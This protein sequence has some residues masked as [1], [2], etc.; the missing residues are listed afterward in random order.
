MN[1]V[2]LDNSLDDEGRAL[3]FENPED[4]VTAALP[5]DVTPALEKLTQ[6]GQQGLYAAGFFSYE[7][8]YLMEPRLAPL[9]PEERDTPL[10]WFGIYRAPQIFTGKD[11]ETYLD[12]VGTGTYSV[13]DLRFSMMEEDY[14]ECFSYVKE[15]IAQGDI[16]QLNLTLKGYFQLA[17][18][19]VALYKD[20][21]T[22]QKVAFGAVIKNNFGTILSLSP[23]LFLQVKDGQAESRPMK[24][25]AQRGRTPE[26]DNEIKAWLAGDEKSRAENLM[27]VDLMRND[28][29]RVSKLGS[30]EVHAPYAVETYR[31]LHQMTTSVTATL[32]DNIS[33]RELLRGLFP[34]GSI[35]G[36]PKVRAMELIRQLETGPRGVYTGSIG[37]LAPNG[38]ACFN[39]A[40]R[41][42]AVTPS[43]CGEIGIGSGVVHDS[44][45]D[46][47]YDECLLKMRFLTDTP[48]T[49]QLI[50]T[51]LFE[52][53]VGYAYY[54]QH[55]ARL[56]KSATYFGFHH[57]NQQIID[58]LHK[59]GAGH[60]PG[61]YRVRLL[62]AEDGIIS[63][64]STP[65]ARPDK[66]AIMH[67]VISDKIMDSSNVFLFHKTT[68]RAF[69][70]DEQ[71]KMAEQ[72]GAD[73]V[74]FINERGELT[75]GS[76]T[77]IF[78][79]QDDKLLTPAIDCGLLAGT[80]RADLI[81]RGKV[82]EAILTPQDLETADDI[83]LGNSVRGL[84]RAKPILARPTSK[85]CAS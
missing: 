71:A 44:R 48:E 78:I 16:Y 37:M 66:H 21:R 17:G 45:A 29:G 31:T 6:A 61:T 47:E 15:M 32:R 51:L 8:G 39:V 49:F 18:D 11:K 81:K 53:G 34:P 30:V 5:Q 67:F 84:L 85:R 25:T 77:N 60:A 83:Y 55:L 65:I 64:T 36:A 46:K 20:L 33:L 59:E 12:T 50:E 23:E 72:H 63:T 82:E 54:D 27:I 7:L 79:S 70:D 35:T 22:K 62:L 56:K 28:L 42:I 3:L 26:E 24:G 76:R 19:P 80:L 40:I 9:I 58:A 38:D 2:F 14:Q 57:D 10:L 75:E 74:I 1:T 73:E 4:V 52:P 69:Y 43:G 68:N 41:T 13:D